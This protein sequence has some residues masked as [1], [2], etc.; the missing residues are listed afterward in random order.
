MWIRIIFTILII[1]V[2]AYFVGVFLVKIIWRGINDVFGSNKSDNKTEFTGNNK[3]TKQKQNF[4]KD[5]AEDV[6]YEEIK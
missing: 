1:F 3:Q 6:D 2:I 5:V 4:R